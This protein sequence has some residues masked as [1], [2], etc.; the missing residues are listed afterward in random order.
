MPAIRPPRPAGIHTR[1]PATSPG[2]P[3]E[4]DAEDAEAA[5]AGAVTTGSAVRS[6]ATG[7]VEAT[8]TAAATR[9]GCAGTTVGEAAGAS[10]ATNACVSQ[11]VSGSSRSVCASRDA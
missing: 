8:G 2:E 10:G 6:A 3:G 7:G 11:R 5:G 1:G 9:G 4:D